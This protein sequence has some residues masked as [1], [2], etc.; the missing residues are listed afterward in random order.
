V[1]VSWDLCLL[2]ERSDKLVLVHYGNED[3]NE[4]ELEAG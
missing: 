1:F 2:N 3:V 4:Q